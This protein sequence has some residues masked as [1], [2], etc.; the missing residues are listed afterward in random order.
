M[1]SNKHY[2]E[3]FWTRMT[4]QWVRTLAAMAYDPS[5]IPRTQR[6]EGE[7]TLQA[8]FE[9]HGYTWYTHTNKDIIE[10]EKLMKMRN[11]NNFT[12]Y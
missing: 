3:K 6:V 7:L 5:L 9:L 12:I 8:V 11:L 10:K 1:N 4:V 2:S